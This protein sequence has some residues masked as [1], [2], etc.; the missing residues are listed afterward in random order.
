M[1]KNQ[2][3]NAGETGLI[4]D[5]GDPIC[6]GVTQPVRVSCVCVHACVYSAVS[7]SL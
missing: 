4:P 7:D 2:P 3:A 6:C 1:V 5:L